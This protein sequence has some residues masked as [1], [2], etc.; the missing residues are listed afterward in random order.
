MRVIRFTKAVLSKRAPHRE[1]RRHTDVKTVRPAGPLSV[2][3]ANYGQTS[4]DIPSGI[5][6]RPTQVGLYTT[7][8]NSGSF[9]CD[10]KSTTGWQLA[11]KL[12]YQPHVVDDQSRVPG[13]VKG[14]AVPEENG[15]EGRD[16]R[17]LSTAESINKYFVIS[18]LIF[19]TLQYF[20]R[21]RCCPWAPD[22][23]E[24]GEATWQNSTAGKVRV[25]YL[26]TLLPSAQWIEGRRRKFFL[27][28]RGW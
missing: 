20:L 10:Q 7:C 13:L 25:E 8:L 27:T 22:A 23:A 14:L 21:R 12:H 15:W 5:T 9:N 17:P 28:L 1:P 16:T 3:W 26:T 2:T 6:I 18:P 11:V 24:Q 19:F 4:G